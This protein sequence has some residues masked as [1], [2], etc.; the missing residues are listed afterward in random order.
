M[1][2]KNQLLHSQQFLLQERRIFDY[3]TGENLNTKLM[4]RQIFYSLGKI[5]IS[6][7]NIRKS[8]RGEFRR[9]TRTNIAIKKSSFKTGQ[10]HPGGGKEIERMPLIAAQNVVCRSV[11]GASF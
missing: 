1:F 4:L 6:W 2:L 10:D 9:R 5:H 7:S 3:S 11:Q 8:Y